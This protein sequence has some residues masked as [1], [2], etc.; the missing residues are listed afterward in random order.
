MN[1]EKLAIHQFLP[2]L[3]PKDAIGN[4]CIIMRD[5]LRRMG[6]KSDIYCEHRNR[7]YRK[8]AIEIRESQIKNAA[9]GIL[10]FHFSVATP[11]L[12]RLAHAYNSICLRYH[13]VTPEAFFDPIKDATSHMVCELGRRQ[14]RMAASISRWGLADSNYNAQDLIDAGMKD[15]KIMALLR[16]YDVIGSAQPSH[17]M[18]ST[19]K[20][21]KR[22]TIL[23]VGRLAPNKRQED[24]I[25]LLKVYQDCIDPKLR[26]ILVGNA[27]S[28]SYDDALKQY[29]KELGLKVA[30]GKQQ[31]STDFDILFSGSVSDEELS[32]Y[33][34]ASDAFVC[35]SE[36]EGFCI[37]LVESM[38]VGLPI[39]AHDATAVPETLGKAGI[40][41]DK[42]NPE[43]FLN[44]L[45]RILTDQD[46]R[47]EI[48]QQA[49][50][51]YD[52]LKLQTTMGEFRD[53]IQR[54]IKE[55]KAT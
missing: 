16:D 34:Q 36:H 52:Q 23:F 28:R 19:L 13:N 31:S 40:V 43:G 38:R 9:E 1:H 8:D 30:I 48:K 3:S 49:K 11:L 33:Y 24:L 46:L 53:A 26:L 6:L 10:I 22:P 5:E 41:L 17:Q 27:Y 29:A 18:L 55:Y 51:R 20:S 32:A 4:E 54:M 12:L 15:V 14:M 45:K 42:F 7:I 50:I 37:P 25:Q 44:G 47:T 35:V 39:L 2:A 21:A